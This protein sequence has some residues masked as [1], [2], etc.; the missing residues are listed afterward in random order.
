MNNY[1]QVFYRREQR[2]TRHL[3]KPIVILKQTDLETCDDIGHVGKNNGEVM[4][5]FKLSEITTAK[6]FIDRIGKGENTNKTIEV[7]KQR[8][9]DKRG[10]DERLGRNNVEVKSWFK[11]PKTDT[12]KC[13]TD[14]IKEGWNT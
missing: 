12:D 7:L 5:W 1:S 3:I 8:K 2:G 10:G 14:R 6:C 9:I 4:S 11:I 13:F